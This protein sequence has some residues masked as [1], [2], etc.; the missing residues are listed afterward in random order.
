MGHDEEPAPPR[1]DDPSPKPGGP[2]RSPGPGAGKRALPQ[3]IGFDTTR[4]RQAG[5]FI[6]PDTAP[7]GL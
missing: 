4:G 6:T 1:G 3:G 5:F 7:P 2:A